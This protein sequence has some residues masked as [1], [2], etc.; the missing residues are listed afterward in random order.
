[1]YQK[2]NN[3]E[4]LSEMMTILR[5]A[6][7]AIDMW[8]SFIPE[9]DVREAMEIVSREGQMRQQENAKFYCIFSEYLCDDQIFTLAACP[10]DE[11]N[12]LKS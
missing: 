1:M 2:K 10:H 12:L 3:F 5:S 8:F 9:R 4:D 11:S 7:D 6:R